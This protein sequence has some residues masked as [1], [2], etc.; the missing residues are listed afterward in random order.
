MQVG[1]L[2]YVKFLFAT[3]SLVVLFYFVPLSETVAALRDI[4]PLWFSIAVIAQFV[5]R[6]AGTVRM[7][8]VAASQGILLSL[9]QL[10]RLLLAVHFYSVLLPGPLFGGSASW[11]KYKQH[12]A[13]SHAAAAT[14]VVNRAVGIGVKVALGVCAWMFDRVSETPMLGFGCVLTVLFVSGIVVLTPQ[15]DSVEQRQAGGGRVGRLAHE[16]L[17]R[18]VLLRRIPRYGKFVILASA[19]AQDLLGTFVILGFAIA[20]GINVDFLTVLWIRAALSLILL[21][22]VTVAGLGVR[23]ASLVGLGALIGLDSVTAV[24]WSFA[25]LAGTLTV[26]AVGGLVEASAT[27]D[28][29]VRYL[30]DRQSQDASKRG[31]T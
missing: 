13:G 27:S 5:M 25:I 4:D 18:I 1:I 29:V 12:G 20:V 26:A 3:V 28:G 14:V 31:E 22:P 9:P 15:P 6:A 30:E 7:Q 24:T 21:L 10:Y 16:M 2:I 23:E 17:R 8:V 11:I 19:F